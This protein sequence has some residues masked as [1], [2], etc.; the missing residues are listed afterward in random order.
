MVD[1][2]RVSLRAS[3]FLKGLPAVS[4]GTGLQCLAG[5]DEVPKA[6]LV[7]ERIGRTSNA[8]VFHFGLDWGWQRVSQAKMNPVQN[9]VHINRP[10]EWLKKVV[11]NHRDHTEHCAEDEAQPHMGLPKTVPGHT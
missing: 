3:T 2:L 8:W 6:L 10:E 1:W 4:E 7:G 9:L 11:S 5:R